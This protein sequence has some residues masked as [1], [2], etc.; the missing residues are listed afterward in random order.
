[1]C[2]SKYQCSVLCRARTINLVR[3]GKGKKFMIGDN[4]DGDSGIETN[5]KEMSTDPAALLH[6]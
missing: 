2:A 3:I 4:V 5:K 1:M 6:K